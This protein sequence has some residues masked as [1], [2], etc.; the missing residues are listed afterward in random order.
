VTDST[1]P[2]LDPAEGRLR[3]TFAA[4]AE[5]VAPGDA[6]GEM[7]DFGA[8]G[9]AAPRV[10]PRRTNRPLLAAATVVVVALAAAGVGLLVRDGGGEETGR[11]DTLGGPPPSDDPL[12]LVTAPRTLVMALQD[13]RNL[14]TSRLL[15]IEDAIALPVTDTAQARSATDAAAAAFEAFVTGSA[16]G[17]AY[18]PGLDA[19]DALGVMRSDIDAYRGPRTLDNIDTAQDVF[20]R[21]AAIVGGLLDAHATF[22]GTIDDPTMRA[23]AEAYGRGLQLDEQTAQLGRLAVL[24]AVLPDADSLGELSLL[25]SEVQQGLD[26]LFAETTGT[27]YEDAAATALAEIEGSGLLEA[28]GAALAAGPTDVAAILG[29]TD[30]AHGQSWPAFLDEVEAILASG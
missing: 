12:A 27:P 17:A 4:R 19:L 20:D 1:A 8:G 6:A 13:E 26:A 25:H 10:R 5:D 29:A 14:A 3:R 30:L 9:R 11:V 2:T 24:T 16:D 18:Q 28:S 15:G 22:A 23:G 7:P 21:Y